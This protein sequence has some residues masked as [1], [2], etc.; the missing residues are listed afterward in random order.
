M[1]LLL[2][3]LG[4]LSTETPSIDAQKVANIMLRS[5]SDYPTLVIIEAPSAQYLVKGC[6]GSGAPTGACLSSSSKDTGVV[7]SASSERV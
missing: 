2:D 6:G 5:V 7:C 3:P 1:T 4:L